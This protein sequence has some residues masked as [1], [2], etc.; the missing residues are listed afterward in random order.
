MKRVR[1]V[2]RLGPKR[3]RFIDSFLSGSGHI[4]TIALATAKI[5]ALFF[6]TGPFLVVIG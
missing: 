1:V 4:S 2:E 6:S 5:E 3:R